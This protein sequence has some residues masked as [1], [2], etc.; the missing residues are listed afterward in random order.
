MP[1]YRIQVFYERGQGVKWSN[2]WHAS[3]VSIPILQG[4][5][6]AEAVPDLLVMLDPSCTLVRFLISDLAGDTFVTTNVGSAGTSAAAGDMLP[7]FNSIKVF[8]VDGSLGRPDYKYIKGY[9]TESTQTN[10]VLIPAVVTGID[11]FVT[12]LLA[13]MAG[14][15]TPL[16]SQDGDEYISASVQPAV[17][18]RQMHRKRKKTVVSP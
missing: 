8:L 9:I 2:V 17:Q 15:A 11:Q 4:T 14:V 12:T 18:M 10:S 5:F 16:V 3:A 1:V 7:L 6:S 13:D